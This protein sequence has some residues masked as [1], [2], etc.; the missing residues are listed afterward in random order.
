MRGLR[1]GSGAEQFVG[2]ALLIAQGFKTNGNI[3]LLR[4]INFQILESPHQF[5]GGPYWRGKGYTNIVREGEH[6]N[7]SC[8]MSQTSG[9]RSSDV[10]PSTAG[11]IDNSSPFVSH[12]ATTRQHGQVLET[13]RT[14]GPKAQISKEV[15]ARS[16]TE[17]APEQR[18]RARDHP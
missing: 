8:R 18:K 3:I 13:Q 4:S 12:R 11:Y 1:W 2:F 15:M 14:S 17:K 9:S 16:I 10:E 7:I 6:S 5:I